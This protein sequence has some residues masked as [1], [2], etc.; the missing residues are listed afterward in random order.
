[1]SSDFSVSDTVITSVTCLHPYLMILKN[2]FS[3]KQQKSQTEGQKHA[4]ISLYTLD[5]H[6]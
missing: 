5:K 6:V 3:P 2:T 4:H 1:M